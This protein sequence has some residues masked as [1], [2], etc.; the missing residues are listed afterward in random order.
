ML[1][2]LANINARMG[3][4]PLRIRIGG[5]SMDASSYT[6]SFTKELLQIDD[7]SHSDYI[8][9]TYGPVLFTVL[10]AVADAVGDL[11]FLIGLSTQRAPADSGE[12][13]ALA[14]AAKGALGERLDALLL[15]NV[16][17]SDDAKNACLL[18]AGA[19]SVWSAWGSA[20]LYHSRLHRR[21]W[22]VHRRHQ[23]VLSQQPIE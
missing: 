22:A 20:K 4:A 3:S 12:S 7:T 9:V 5:N 17:T 10:N 1:N 19:G 23:A 6:P 16:S 21:P 15:G 18:L 2:Y 14:G 8:L 13:Y 11:S